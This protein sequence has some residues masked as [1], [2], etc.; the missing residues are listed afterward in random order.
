LD[1]IE[2]AKPQWNVHAA[3][4]A[5]IIPG[6]GHY[7]L[8]QRQ[9]GAVIA[10]SIGF[11][12]LGGLL[13]GGIDVINH[14]RMWF[15]GQVLLFPSLAANVYRDFV[16]DRYAIRTEDSNLQ[17]HNDPP[18][19]LSFG[20]V[21]E[22]GILYTALAGLLNLL[23]II[24]VLYCDPVLRRQSERHAQVATRFVGSRGS[25]P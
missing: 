21:E 17:P 20:R 2:P 4:A 22:Q 23:A 15:L 6:L 5:W 16:L 25:N 7:M 8:G 9:R 12:W 14:R 11:L 1:G 13:I 24:D 19:E 3:L 10:A 18:Y